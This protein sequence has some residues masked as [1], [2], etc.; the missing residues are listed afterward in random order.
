MEDSKP[1]WYMLDGIT[2][3]SLAKLSSESSP[4]RAGGDTRSVK[5]CLNKIFLFCKA[6]QKAAVGQKSVPFCCKAQQKAKVGQEVFFCKAQQKG[7][8]VSKNYLFVCKGQQN[9]TS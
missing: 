9:G 7:K 3:S 4:Q 8:N 5:N 1:F 2:S 6:Q